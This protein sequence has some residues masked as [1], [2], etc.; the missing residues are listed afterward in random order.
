MQDLA[1]S[2]AVVLPVITSAFWGMYDIV[3]L[4]MEITGVILDSA[5]E[6]IWLYLQIDMID[7][8]SIAIIEDLWAKR[9]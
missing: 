2:D 3:E 1:H 8:I 7:M 6:A 5:L 9:T 4:T